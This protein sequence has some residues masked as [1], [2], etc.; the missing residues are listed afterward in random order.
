ML[1][2]LATWLPTGLFLVLLGLGLGFACSD[3]GPKMR[4]P[5]GNPVAMP[6]AMEEMIDPSMQSA[7]C[8]ESQP[9][10]GETCPTVTRAMIT[11]RYAVR[12]CPTSGY[13]VVHAMCCGKGGIWVPCG[14]DDPCP[15]PG[16][17]PDAGM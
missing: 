7:E 12:Q 1:R 11:C 8:P 5:T 16:S 17:D 9:K 4:R 6:D 14:I 15:E 10:D 3:D 2:P 13:N